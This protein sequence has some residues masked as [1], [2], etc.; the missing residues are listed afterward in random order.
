MRSALLLVRVGAAAEEAKALAD[1]ESLARAVP[2]TRRLQVCIALDR[3]LAYIYAWREQ[4]A[5]HDGAARLEPIAEYRGASAG[6]RAAYHYVVATDVEP[7]W[8]KEL[9]TWYEKEHMPGLAAVPGNVQCARL[10]NVDG[11]P[12]YHACYDLVEPQVLERPEWLAVRHTEWS[13]RVRPHFRNT[14]RVMFRTVLD[15]R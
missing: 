5:A 9:H 6:A 11:A 10:R 1:G 8:D 3:P 14:V 15:A 12:R 7:G 2:G 13:G 4:P